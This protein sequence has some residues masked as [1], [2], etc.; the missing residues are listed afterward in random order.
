MYHVSAQ[1]VDE[2]MINV[3][4]YD[5]DY[6]YPMSRSHRSLQSQADFHVCHSDTEHSH[7]ETQQ[8]NVEV[9]QITSAEDC[10]SCLLQRLMQLRTFSHSGPTAKSHHRCSN[11]PYKQAFKWLV[12]GKTEKGHLKSDSYDS[13]PAD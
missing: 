12:V 6:Y 8:S 9:T 7:T 13:F 11:E 10:F 2:R 4:Y 3:H 1:G 5:Y